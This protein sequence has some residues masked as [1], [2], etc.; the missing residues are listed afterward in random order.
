MRKNLL[1]ILAIFI[2]L[3]LVTACADKD[4]AG[5][6]VVSSKKYTEQLIVGNIIGEYL[7]ENTDL[8]VEM[9]EGLGSVFVLQEAMENGEIDMYIEYTGT[10]FEI[11]DETYD[12]SLSAEDVFQITKDTYQERYN[13]K[14]LEPLG[15]NN[16]YMIAMRPE[17]HEELGV[18]TYSDLRGHTADLVFGAGPEV[19]ER[20][21]GYKGLIDAYDFDEFADKVSIDPDLIYEPASSGEIDVF[22]GS[23]TDSR[24]DEYNL[25]VLEDDKDYFP[26][27]NASVIVRQETLDANSGLEEKLNELAGAIT[28]NHMRDMHGRVNLDGETDKQVAL[29]FLKEEGFIE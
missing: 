14:W 17:L 26:P 1:M 9:K 7:K 6:V 25:K 22:I 15:F 10:G 23:L 16:Q 5:K 11:I 2:M 8:D 28:D 19:Y 3:M 18:E 24:I 12:P 13:I 29:D 21:D 4:E 27:Y 20:D